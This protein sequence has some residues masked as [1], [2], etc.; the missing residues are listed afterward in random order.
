MKLAF[1]LLQFIFH[2]LFW[3]SQTEQE[4]IE[5]SLEM[6]GW[7]KF[8]GYFLYKRSS[9]E[10]YYFDWFQFIPCQKLIL[11]DNF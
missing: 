8:Q 7:E 5:M 4:Q 10:E 1:V 2:K 9:I 3:I 11:T 6:K